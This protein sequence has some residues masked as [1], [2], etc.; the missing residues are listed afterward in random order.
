MAPAI[1]SN[2]LGTPPDEA[3]SAE[4]EAPTA[5]ATDQRAQPSEETET[6]DAIEVIEQ[7]IRAIIQHLETSDR[8]NAEA[9]RQL[10]SEMHEIA[11]RTDVGSVGETDEDARSAITRIEERLDALADKFEAIQSDA[12]YPDTSLIEERLS[13]L[14]T[15]IQELTGPQ[16]AQ[17]Q[18]WPA[19]ES[20]DADSEA[21]FHGEDA[22][23]G[24][25][26]RFAGLAHNLQSSLSEP[27]P[28]A[29]LIELREIVSELSDKVDAMAARDPMPGEPGFTQHI[30]ELT[31]RIE[32]AEARFSETDSPSLAEL[33][34]RIDAVE[35]SLHSVATARDDTSKALEEQFATLVDQLEASRQAMTDA[36]RLAAAEATS[37]A[38]GEAVGDVARQ[39]AQEAIRSAQDVAVEAAQAAARSYL[40]T[41][42]TAEPG[43]QNAGD[44]R[45][46]EMLREGLQELR[47]DLDASD[48]KTESAFE[49]VQT[50]LESIAQR[51]SSVEGESADKASARDEEPISQRAEGRIEP[52]MESGIDDVGTGDS[53][54]G[55]IEPRL[56]EESTKLP[57]A[58][59]SKERAEAADGR[60][61]KEKPIKAEDAAEQ[62]VRPVE[63]DEMSEESN[64][65]REP[66]SGPPSSI[67]PNRDVQARPSEEQKSIP[68]GKDAGAS[69]SEDAPAAA[70]PAAAAPTGGETGGNVTASLRGARSTNELL[71]AARRAA[72]SAA[73]QNNAGPLGRLN[74]KS[75]V[76]IPLSRHGRA[77]AAANKDKEV[78]SA[79]RAER[80][81]AAGA[82][83]GRP[84]ARKSI[85]LAVAAVMLLAGSIEIYNLLKTRS[86]EM[87][88]L[89][90]E[91]S[92]S[93]PSAADITGPETAEPALPEAPPATESPL[94]D[95]TIDGGA[96]DLPEEPQHAT[97]DEIS[98]GTIIT[99]SE[100]TTPTIAEM[101]AEQ[102]EQPPAPETQSAALTPSPAQDAEPAAQTADTD[103]APEL[104]EKIGSAALRQAAIQGN[105]IAQFEVATRLAEGRG[106][107][108]DPAA[109][110]A[111]YRRAAA[112]GLAP[113]QYRLGS[114]YEKGTGIAQD[115][116]AARI[117]YKRAAAQG[118]RK[119][120]H[121]LAVL[122]ADGVSGT[123]NF[124]VA[125]RWF[126]AAAEL[127]LADSQYNLGILCARGLG[128]P[129][130]FAESYKWFSILANRGDQDAAIRRDAVATKLDA[131]VLAATKLAVQTWKPKRMDPDANAVRLPEKGW[132]AQSQEKPSAESGADFIRDVQKLLTDLGYEPGPVDGQWGPK[133]KRAVES[134]QADAGLEPTG[135]LTP[136]LLRKLQQSS[137]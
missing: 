73:E 107:Q 78:S 88:P 54:T 103:D 20:D 69:R 118:N 62:A 79:T 124:E 101:P 22:S 125:A 128:V 110:A 121:N 61:S 114:L 50:T 133:T 27:S 32:A 33:T 111:W 97:A 51:L 40:E 63:P 9:L 95:G 127:D 85:V 58:A 116:G 130:N 68:R 2:A 44:A 104:S 74:L 136:D 117:W 64:L 30:A 72:Q 131:Q 134:F 91:S 77:A 93:E 53:E 135:A 18:A 7:T 67:L 4:T 83:S 26:E 3:A 115:R 94:P 25:S 21:T 10:Q 38:V 19:S 119:A 13:A 52:R 47:N 42:A 57:L 39:A 99:A 34:G 6:A 87:L 43:A 29:E 35:Q 106:I 28:P 90:A 71:A 81:K 80:P 76:R 84:A 14:A 1:A 120:M 126:Q 105:P 46:L 8:R 129:Q 45:A 16:Y 55:K 98:T 89:P 96:L 109:A 36:A 70:T 60:S 122:H 59:S 92:Q 41:T 65:P 15:Q 113:A 66:G 12:Q 108:A 132:T 102:A 5:A 23:E 137:S 24:L 100:S 37:E 82:A 48:R 11:A 31:R 56:S 86:D 112:A 49:T 17:T 75:R 123:P